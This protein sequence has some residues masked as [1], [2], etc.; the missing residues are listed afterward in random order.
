MA[1]LLALTSVLGGCDRES[2][3]SKPEKVFGGQGIGPGEFVNPRAVATGPDGAVYV[4]D[5]TARV[6]RFT[7]DGEYEA[8]WRMPEWQAGKP[9]GLMVDTQ[10]HVWVADTHYAR[11]I[12]YDRDGHELERFGSNGEGPGQF[13]FPTDIAVAPD[14]TRYVSEYGGNDRIS[15]FSAKW[16]YLGS[17]GCR[18]EG[19][20]A[21]RRPQTIALDQD[22]TLWVADAGGH[23]ICHFS[24]DGKWL[25]SFGKIGSAPGEFKF[26]YGLA[27]CPDGT[28]LVSEFENNRV[29]RLDRAG[30]C[31][32]TWGGPGTQP[33]QFAETW[34]VALGK[35]GRFYVVD[36]KNHRVQIFRM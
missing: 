14:G 2:S 3:S 5:K 28:M 34:G 9:T 36:C 6:Q 35:D 1:W 18:G 27:L 4:I 29:Q 8:S 12:I 23:R 30:K 13:I 11:V 26:P 25:S 19:E 10:N 20:T 15:R 16:E 21:L 22:G 31:L 7:A 17:F 24:A 33:G 32:A